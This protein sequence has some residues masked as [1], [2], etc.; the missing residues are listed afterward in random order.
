[1]LPGGVVAVPISRVGMPEGCMKP[2]SNGYPDRSVPSGEVIRWPLEVFGPC[3]IFFTAVIW[4]GVRHVAVF[5]PVHCKGW[6]GAIDPY[7]PDEG[8]TKVAG[9]K[10]HAARLSITPSTSPSSA[11]HAARIALVNRF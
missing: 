6:P 7:G 2:P 3:A 11:S 10:W 8:K 1:M 9:S 4:A 5:A